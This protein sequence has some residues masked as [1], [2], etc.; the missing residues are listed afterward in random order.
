MELGPPKDVGIKLSDGSLV[1]RF[2]RLVDLDGNH[3]NFV[4]FS[5]SASVSGAL[6]EFLPNTSLN[7]C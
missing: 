4:H 5:L 6:S 7:K 1:S 3:P 2:T